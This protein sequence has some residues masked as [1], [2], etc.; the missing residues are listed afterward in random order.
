MNEKYYKQS[1]KYLKEYFDYL[2]SVK[3]RSETT[4]DGFFND[5]RVFLR[6]LKV[7]HQQATEEDFYNISIT[8]V[9]LEWL[10]NV[11]KGGDLWLS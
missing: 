7:N 10:N 11:N 6:W 1:P 9:P 3:A 5:I 8:D 4:I 2:S